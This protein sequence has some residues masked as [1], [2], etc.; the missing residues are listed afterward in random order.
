MACAGKVTTASERVRRARAAQSRTKTGESV[1]IKSLALAAL[2][3]CSTSPGA[4][5]SAEPS[6]SSPDS[7]TEP[8]LT[9]EAEPD[10]T[11]ESDSACESDP[12]GDSGSLSVECH[13]SLPSRRRSAA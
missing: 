10:L 5:R 11:D 7:T 6:E 13:R 2:A 8:D 9:D 4:A 12:A 3:A 1:T